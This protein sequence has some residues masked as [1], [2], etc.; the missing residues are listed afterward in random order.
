MSASICRAVLQCSKNLAMKSVSQIAEERGL[1]PRS[2]QRACERLCIEKVEGVYLLDGRETK[3][4]VA[5]LHIGRGRP[6]KAMHKTRVEVHASQGKMKMM[7]LR[8]AQQVA[9][10][11]GIT[12]RAVQHVCRYCVQ[13]IGG[14]YLLTEQDIREVKLHLHPGW[15]NTPRLWG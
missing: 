7:N 9:D 2:V 3:K 4:V 15:A 6:R 10:E 13:K 11:L 8:T 12:V 5:A 1:S 14:K